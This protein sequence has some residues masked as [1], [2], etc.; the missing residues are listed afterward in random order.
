VVIFKGKPGGMLWFDPTV[1]RE[2]ELMRGQVP[3]SE[4]DR[5]TN[6][7]EEGSLADA[8]A[9]VQSIRDRTTTTTSTTTTTVPTP[10][11]APAVVATSTA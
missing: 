10:T 4:M 2:T 5:L 3:A 6:G 9:Y 8:E 1:E 7:Q 11:T